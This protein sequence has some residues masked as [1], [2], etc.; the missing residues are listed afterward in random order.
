MGGLAGAR[1]P[2]SPGS[3]QCAFSSMVLYAC[4]AAI[5]SSTILWNW[6]LGRNESTGDI[7]CKLAMV[8]STGK[9]GDARLRCCP[10][11]EQVLTSGLLKAPLRQE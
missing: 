6:S 9:Q 10:R 7:P 8:P 2:G 11:E 3:S 4:R 5:V 1:G